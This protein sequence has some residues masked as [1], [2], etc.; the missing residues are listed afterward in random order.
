[1]ERKIL[2]H[3]T[4]EATATVRFEHKDVVIEQTID[5]KM[6]VPGSMYV[7]EQMGIEFTKAHQLKALNAY[8]DTLELQIDQGVIKPQEKPTESSYSPPPQDESNEDSESV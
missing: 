5:L 2:S 3:D 1:M 4:K 7:F 6:V 8:T